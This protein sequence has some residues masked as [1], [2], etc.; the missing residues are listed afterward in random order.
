[1][2][3]ICLKLCKVS[4]FALDSMPL[5]SANLGLNSEYQTPTHCR[6][7]QTSYFKPWHCM[8][9]LDLNNRQAQHMSWSQHPKTSKPK[10]QVGDSTV[11]PPPDTEKHYQGG[12][13]QSIP[14]DKSHSF[15]STL[16]PPGLLHH[17]LVGPHR[18]CWSVLIT[19]NHATWAPS[20]CI[21][22]CGYN[23]G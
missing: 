18:I 22:S 4:S 7:Y 3:L 12:L 13:S 21:W 1:M 16:S 17:P 15:T 23:H 11:Q 14:R 20:H 2:Y 8:K 9:Y 6:T 19:P 5:P 10:P